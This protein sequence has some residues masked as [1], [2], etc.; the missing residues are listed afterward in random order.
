[1]PLDEHIEDRHGER[2]PGVEFLGVSHLLH[3]AFFTGLY[4]SRC[5][6]YVVTPRM[7]R[8][9]CLQLAVRPHGA[10]RRSCAWQRGKV[11]CL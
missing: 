7:Q 4:D 10:E 8:R 9:P 1:M 2:Q 3:M 6:P 11:A 5:Q